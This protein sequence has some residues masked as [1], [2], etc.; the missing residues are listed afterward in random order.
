MYETY[1]YHFELLNIGYAAYLTFFGLCKQRLP[2]H[3]RP[4]HLAHGRRPATSTSTGPTTSSSGWPRRRC[5]SASTSEISGGDGRADAVRRAAR[6]AAGARVGGRLGAHG[7]PVVPRQHRPGPP[8]RLPRAP[9][10]GARTRTSRWPRC[11]STCAACRPAST[12]DRPTERG[13]RRARPD[14]RASTAS[15]WPRPTARPSTRCSRWPGRCSSTS[16]STCSTSST[17]CGRRS[18]RKSQGAGARAGRDGRVRRAPRTCS[19]CAATRSPRRSTTASP[20]GRSARRPRGADYWRPIIARAPAD[21]RR[22]CEAWE[23]PPA[24]GPPPAEVNEPFTVML[25]GITTVHG[26]RSG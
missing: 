11:A 26:R 20:A 13:A 18:G 10:L 3:L 16:R 25:W 1:Q 14:H 8:R 5:G 17:G 9:D 4:V 23:P 2:R 6:D 7:R 21:L 19:S 22:R 12:I 24:L 15:C